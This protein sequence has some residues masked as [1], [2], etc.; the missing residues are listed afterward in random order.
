[1]RNGA[2]GLGDGVGQCTGGGVQQ[3]QEPPPGSDDC[4]GGH[5]QSPGPAV[6]IKLPEA[7]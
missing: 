2:H 5:K 6:E 4:R 3:R 7:V 1:M